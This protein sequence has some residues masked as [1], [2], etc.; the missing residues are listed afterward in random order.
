LEKHYLRCQKA[1]RGRWAAQF[2]LSASRTIT[3]A[4]SATAVN[5]AAS[6]VIRP[7]R[8]MGLAARG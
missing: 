3:V 6:A 7:T 5:S 1:I 2:D 8:L 4:P